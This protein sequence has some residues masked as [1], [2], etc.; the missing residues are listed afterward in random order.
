MTAAGCCVSSTK[1]RW[2]CRGA[3]TARRAGGG[4]DEVRRASAEPGHKRTLQSVFG[5]VQVGR[6]AYRARGHN[7]LYPA[8]HALN[9]PEEKQSHGLRRL[10]AIESTRGS[11]TGASDAITRATG[12]RVANR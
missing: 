4:A 9:L 2:T 10:A 11:F 1:T 6:I 3:R 12:Q 7:N 8:D 5:D